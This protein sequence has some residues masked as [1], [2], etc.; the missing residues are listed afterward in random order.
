MPR[1]AAAGVRI[2]TVHK[3]KGLEFPVV[4]IPGMES[5]GRVEGAGAAWYDSPLVGLTVNL[6]PFD[7]PKAKSANIFYEIEKER[8]EK[9]R[10]AEAKRLFYVAC[11]RTRCHLV[12][13]GV[14]PDR[15][16]GPS[17]HSFLTGT[18]GGP[19]QTGSF[20]ALPAA[21]RLVEVPT[22][23]LGAYRG[24]FSGSQPLPLSPRLAEYAAARTLD[25]R[26]ERRALGAAELN[27]ARIASEALVLESETLDACAYDDFARKVAPSVF[28][29]L[30]HAALESA[31]RGSPPS[32]AERRI[33]DS[34]PPDCRAVLAEEAHR[35]AGLFMASD[36][37]QRA[38]RAVE[39]RTEWAFVLD[40]GEDFSLVG[41]MD[42]AFE[43]ESVSGAAGEVFV[44]DFKTDRE[45]RE[46]EY[47]LQLQLYR[48]A[49]AAI[50]PGHRVRSCLFWLRSGEVQ[51]IE[52]EF[53]QPNILRWARSAAA[54][55]SC[56]N[57][58]QS[59]A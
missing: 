11:T 9:R 30:C 49:A 18:E 7:D 37:G 36:I 33:L 53:S 22:L 35:M 28:G 16:R 24:L 40:L 4:I 2:M 45:R 10:E 20:P 46:G 42:L 12:F 39:A 8:E 57:E 32:P 21:V 5:G 47:D 26:Y 15:S 29:E 48:R 14:D 31:L 44:V 17:F 43:E 38:R 50:V 13:A 34:L 1:E 23:S 52:T 58:A 51:E 55:E 54:A 56:R 59:E 6:K 19:D 25:R 3:A 27:A 41:R